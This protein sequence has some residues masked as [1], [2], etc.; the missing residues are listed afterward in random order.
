MLCASVAFMDVT[1][2]QPTGGHPTDGPARA[3]LT[4]LVEDP[5]DGSQKP[6]ELWVATSDYIPK[7][8]CRFEEHEVSVHDMR[9]APIRFGLDL[10]GFKY[11]SHHSSN[12]PSPAVLQGNTEADPTVALRPYLEE[13]ISLVSRELH[14]KHLW[15]CSWAVR[16]ITARAGIGC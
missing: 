11:I 14:M 16:P 15:V 1:S 13:T 9:S 12:L 6:Y 3:V 4:F 8:N 10:T 5:I 7:T 2:G